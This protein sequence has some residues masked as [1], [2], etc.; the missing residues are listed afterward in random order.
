VAVYFQERQYT[1]EFILQALQGLAHLNANGKTFGEQ[2][3]DLSPVSIV[4]RFT[5]ASFQ[6][7]ILDYL[8]IRD[9]VEIAQQQSHLSQEGKSGTLVQT[10]LNDGGSPRLDLESPFSAKNELQMSLPYD[11]PERI[12]VNQKDIGL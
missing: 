3:G 7:K 8:K 4:I 6:V 12:Y 5:P 1:Y 10:M 2:H 11:A 9:L